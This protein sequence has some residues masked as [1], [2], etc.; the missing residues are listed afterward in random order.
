MATL[1]AE[2]CREVDAVGDKEGSCLGGVEGTFTTGFGD[3]GA[4]TG[5][6]DSF[7][8]ADDACS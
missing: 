8:R 5:G 3:A 4:L 7:L 2:S 1:E 6:G